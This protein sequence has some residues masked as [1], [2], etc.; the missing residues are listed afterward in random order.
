VDLSDSDLL[1]NGFTA[2]HS[3]SMKVEKK[4][5]YLALE[6]SKKGRERHHRASQLE[7]CCKMREHQG[8]K[9]HFINVSPARE[10][11]GCGVGV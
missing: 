4:E 11:Y 5:S 6:E 8:L 1:G 7:A 9:P 2:T 3:P 10:P